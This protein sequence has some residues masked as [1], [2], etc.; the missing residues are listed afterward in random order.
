MTDLRPDLSHS[1]GEK[2]HSCEI[3]SGLRPGDEAM[4][5]LLVTQLHD[6]LMIFMVGE[7]GPSKRPRL[8]SLGWFVDF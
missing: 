3:K 5:D 2:I 8:A 1:C 7:N 4:T 6:C